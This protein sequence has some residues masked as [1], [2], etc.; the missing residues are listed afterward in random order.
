MTQ[1]PLLSETVKVPKKQQ[2]FWET[3]SSSYQ[4]GHCHSANYFLQQFK[5]RCEQAT[6]KVISHILKI[7]TFLLICDCGM[8]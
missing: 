1:Q 4:L 5:K 2:E 3:F 8:L 7:F 6:S